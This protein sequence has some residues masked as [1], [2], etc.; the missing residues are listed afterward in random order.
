[1][2]IIIY[3]DLNNFNI[4]YIRKIMYLNNFIQV[5]K[6]ILLNEIQVRKIFKY[7]FNLKTFFN[8]Y[9]FSIFHIY[10]WMNAK[11]NENE[12]YIECRKRKFV[13]VPFNN[14]ELINLSRVPFQRKKI[15]QFKKNNF[16]ER[17][18]FSINSN[19]LYCVFHSMS[20]VRLC[21]QTRI[22]CILFFSECL[23]KC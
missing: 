13:T 8:Q 16:F 12:F 2:C 6:T 17:I 3:Q 5:A 21:I 18:L 9:F 11:Q 7:K 10:F 15:Q 19:D 1:M 20:S 14:R 4:L 23:C 22:L